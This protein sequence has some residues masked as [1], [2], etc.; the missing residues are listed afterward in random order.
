VFHLCFLKS[1][2]E[3]KD[4]KVSGIHSEGLGC[5][6]L[7]PAIWV[8]CPLLLCLLSWPR[9]PLLVSSVFCSPSLSLLTWSGSVCRHSLWTPPGISAPGY[10]LIFSYKKLSLPPYLGEVMSFPFLFLFC[11]SFREWDL[12]CVRKPLPSAPPITAAGVVFVFF[13]RDSGSLCSF[14]C[15]AGLELNIQ[16]R[17]VSHS[18]RSTSSVSRVLGLKVSTATPSHHCA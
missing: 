10:T 9:V 12:G 17:L 8:I 5:P 6:S 11:F 4:T 7:Y 2:N 13:F 15:L 1:T 14:G 18:E 3:C 16:T